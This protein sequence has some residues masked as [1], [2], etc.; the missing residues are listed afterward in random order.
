M[1]KELTD[2]LETVAEVTNELVKA[3][4]NLQSCLQEIS[5]S[6]QSSPEWMTLTEASPKVGLSI[7]QMRDR[8]NDGR[9]KHGKHYINV[10]D[11]MAPRYRVN[12]RAID[13]VQA[14]PPEKR[15]YR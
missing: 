11:G 6:E 9:W 7:R 10:S 8:I 14:L 4:A 15:R 1:S 13:N 2:A 5:K 3:I 12:C